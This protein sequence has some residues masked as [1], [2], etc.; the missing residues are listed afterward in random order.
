V[1]GADA[2]SSTGI[3]TVAERTAASTVPLVTTPAKDANDVSFQI[4]THR[5]YRAG[6]AR[7]VGAYQPTPNP[8]ALTVPYRWRRGA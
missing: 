8:S 7:M 6:S 1:K 5:R 2:L 3:P 4:G